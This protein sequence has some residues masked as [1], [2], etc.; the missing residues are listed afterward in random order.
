MHVTSG[1]VLVT[2]LTG[3]EQLCRVEMR[4]RSASSTWMTH[5]TATVGRATLS[6]REVPCAEASHAAQTDDVA[7]ELNPDDLYQRLR[8]A[9][10]Q[11]GP[12]FRGIVG[13]TVFTV[14]CRPCRR[15]AT[16]FGQAGSRNFSCIR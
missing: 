7:A 11:H 3:D 9:G 2:T 1:T 10:Q 12:A 15:A 4:T 6:D 14:R 13:L 16:F 5:A 8:G